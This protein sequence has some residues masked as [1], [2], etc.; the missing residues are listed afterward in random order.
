LGHR[1]ELKQERSACCRFVESAAFSTLSFEHR[2]IV[3]AS[4]LPKAGFHPGSSPGQA[5]SAQCLDMP[6]FDGGR[7]RGYVSVMYG[8]GFLRGFLGF[9]LLGSCALDAH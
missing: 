7:R 6:R 2:L 8:S 1:A 5:F 3:Q 4:L 9:R